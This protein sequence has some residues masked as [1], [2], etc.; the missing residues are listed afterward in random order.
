[1]INKNIINDLRDWSKRKK[2]SPK[3]L[4]LDTGVVNYV[5]GIQKEVFSVKDITDAWRGKV[6]EHIVGQELL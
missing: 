5:A 1:M 6:A 2:R 3:L 4:W